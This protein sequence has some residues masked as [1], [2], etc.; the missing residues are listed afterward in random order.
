MDP[1][2]V[3]CHHIPEVTHFDQAVVYTISFRN[4][5]NKAVKIVKIEFDLSNNNVDYN[6]NLISATNGGIIKG[7]KVVWTLNSLRQGES[8]IVSFTLRMPEFW[9]PSALLYLFASVN[10][11]CLKTPSSHI[12]HVTQITP[13]EGLSWNVSAPAIVHRGQTFQY[14]ISIYNNSPR[15][16]TSLCGHIDY[17]PHVTFLDYHDSSGNQVFLDV[18]MTI[19]AGESMTIVAMVKVNKTA[20]LG[21]DTISLDCD[22]ISEQSIGSG[23]GVCISCQ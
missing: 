6:I 13:W 19:D 9:N 14:I 18:L 7:Q 12:Q 1:L 8:G 11:S 23:H 4:P 21:A 5:N 15:L 16:F 10:I 2:M 3:E 20:P 17:S 22:F